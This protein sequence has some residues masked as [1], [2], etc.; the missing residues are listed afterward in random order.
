LK[1]VAS[2]WIALLTLLLFSPV[3]AQ[4]LVVPVSTRGTELSALWHMTIE[5][6][7]DLAVTHELGHALC[8]EEDEAIANRVAK[9]R[10]RIS[11]SCAT[12]LVGKTESQ[13]SSGALLLASQVSSSVAPNIPALR[14]HFVCSSSYTL[15]HCK[16]DMQVLKVALA[17]YPASELGD[18]TWVLVPSA[19]WTFMLRAH[20]LHSGVP[21]LTALAAR[22]TYFEEALVG[23]APERVDELRDIWGLGRDGLLDLAV[24]HELGHALCNEED[25]TKASRVAKMLKDG[26]SPSCATNLVGKTE[27]QRS[28]GTLLL[29]SRV[30]S[31]L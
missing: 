29:A 17:K 5:D 9:L 7:L 15:K 26:I 18:W 16:N 8:N 12:N 11:P 20:H 31:S 24:R 30:S 6:L 21:A 27:S 23:W 3:A 2:F 13:R 14:Q 1:L 25:E 4:A 10:E 28:H 19:D 22:T